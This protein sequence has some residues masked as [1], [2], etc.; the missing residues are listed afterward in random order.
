[1]FHNTIPFNYQVSEEAS[2]IFI[3]ILLLAGMII[4][5]VYIGIMAQEFSRRYK[6]TE[7]KAYLGMANMLL[8]T[9]IT[10]SL[11]KKRT[12]RKYIRANCNPCVSCCYYYKLLQHS[13][14]KFV[15]VT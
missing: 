7:A 14:V 13:K 5:Y 4:R 12:F 9:E 15:C 10:F 6:S 2:H 8:N 3:A 1:M 11:E